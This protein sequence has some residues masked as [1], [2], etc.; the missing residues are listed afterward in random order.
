MALLAEALGLSE[1]D[2][3]ALESAAAQKRGNSRRVRDESP[4]PNN[5][6]ALTTS[7]VGRD[8]DLSELGAPSLHGDAHIEGLRMRR[9]HLAVPRKATGILRTK[10]QR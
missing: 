6:P 1:S 5:L 8:G 7:L 3:L 4:P 2:R 9:N 10:A